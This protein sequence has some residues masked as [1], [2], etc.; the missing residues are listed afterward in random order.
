MLLITCLPKHSA[1]G[2][3]KDASRRWPDSETEALSTFS[4]STIFPPL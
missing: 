2:K 1:Y 3:W 4:F